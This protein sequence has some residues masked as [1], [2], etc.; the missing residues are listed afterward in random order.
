MRKWKCLWL[1]FLVLS[2][3]LVACSDDNGCYDYLSDE[4]VGEIV[5]D[6]VG[7][8][9]RFALSTMYPGDVIDLEP[10]VSYRYMDNLRYRW[11]ALPLTNYQYQPVQEGNALVYPPAD[12]ISCEKK[13]HWTV[14]LNPGTYRFFYMV[15][16]T[17]RGLKAYFQFGNYGTV[18]TEGTFDG[19]YMLSE[20]DGQTDIDVYTS[21]L[22]L[23]FGGDS[24]AP[25]YYSKV[26][27]HTIPGHPRFIHGSH[28]GGTARDGYVVATD[29]TM[30]RLSGEGLTTMDTWNDMFYATP[31]VFNPQDFYFMNNADFLVNN[32]KLHVLYT[33]QTNDRKFSAAIPGDYKAAPFLAHA[34]RTS[35]NPVEGA[36]NADQIIYDLSSHAFRPYYSAAS[37]ISNF[38][39]TSGDAYIDANHMPEDPVAIFNG[40][41]ERT[42]CI[43]HEGGT[44]YLYRFNFYNRVDNGDLSAD[45]SRSRLDLSGC[46]DMGRARLFA[47]NNYGH[48][49]YYATDNA[50]YSFSPSSGATTSSTIYQCGAGETVTA[51]YSWNSAG[52]PTAGVILWVAVWDENKHEGKLLEYEVDPNNGTPRWMY[53]EDMAPGHANPYVT[54]GWGKIISMTCTSTE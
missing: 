40:Y 41:A 12:T 16:D 46:T 36:I 31:D 47:A 17:V 14:D 27:G 1:L 13:L 53:G 28:T 33:D 32:G 34:T 15:E 44:Y 39:T 38:K 10:H 23:I 35:D 26:T 9:N 25:R 2:G 18:K 21:S 11:L 30:L 29:Q 20:Y 45:G 54:T 42:Y 24:V 22:M 8:E 5:I 43:T 52:F 49:F 50:V 3:G 7:I 4:E 6:T 19:L 48:A 51:I 37:G